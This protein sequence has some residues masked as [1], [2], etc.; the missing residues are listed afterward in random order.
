MPD[1]SC[2]LNSVASSLRT[3]VSQHIAYWHLGCF[4]T[5]TGRLV[6]HT[7]GKPAPFCIRQ[8][9][10][11]CRNTLFC[12]YL[13]P[14]LLKMPA[15]LDPIPTKVLVA[16]FLVSH[17]Y[18]LVCVC[19]M[20]VLGIHRWIK[21]HIHAL[22]DLMFNKGFW[23]TLV[24]QDK[25]ISLILVKFLALLMNIVERIWYLLLPL[26]S[27]LFKCQSLLLAGMKKTVG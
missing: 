21:M 19:N 2:A 13:Q 7:V 26:H 6:L 1:H 25:E 3:F 10:L 17:I 5:S 8:P 4:A 24:F 14:V 23:M 27:M 18:C 12:F 9:Y 15:G 20:L 16:L 11:P 22:K